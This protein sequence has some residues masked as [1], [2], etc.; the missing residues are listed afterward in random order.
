MCKPPAAMMAP[1]GRDRHAA[2]AAEIDLLAAFVG[3][4]GLGV[5]AAEGLPEDGSHSLITPRRSPLKRDL[6]AGMI[7]QRIDVTGVAGQL[8]NQLAGRGSQSRTTRSL[9]PVASD[10]P[11]GLTA[12][13]RT[14]PWWA[15][16]VR[17]GLG[18]A[19]AVSQ[20]DNSTVAAAAVERLARR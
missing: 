17:I 19:A 7:F 4:K 2:H 8:A 16:I 3:V 6:A 20:T 12:M 15:S 1:I 9:P 13:A 5:E 11:S 18:V 14:Q 10:L